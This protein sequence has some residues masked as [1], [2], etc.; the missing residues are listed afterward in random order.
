LGEV[1]FLF[2][3][4]KVHIEDQYKPQLLKLA[5]QAKGITGYVIQVKA[6]QAKGIGELHGKF[7]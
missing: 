2:G 3:N 6:K 1:T 4:D 5:Q 7:D